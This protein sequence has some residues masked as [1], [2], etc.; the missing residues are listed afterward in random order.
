MLARKKKL[1]FV[2]SLDVA[3]ANGWS[4]EKGYPVFTERDLAGHEYLGTLQEKDRS[5]F[6]PLT[7]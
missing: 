5:R 3:G 6:G 1:W 2:P 7:Q 4:L